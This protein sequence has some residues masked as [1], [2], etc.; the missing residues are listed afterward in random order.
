MCSLAKKNISVE[1]VILA[2]F[3]PYINQTDTQIVNNFL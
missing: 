2:K 1:E 3:K